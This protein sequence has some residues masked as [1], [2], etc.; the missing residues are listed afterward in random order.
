MVRASTASTSEPR[1]A[2]ETAGAAV[3]QA[4]LKA[5]PVTNRAIVWKP[6]CASVSARLTSVTG[7]RGR[8]I[9]RRRGGTII[10]LCYQG[11]LHAFDCALI[12]SARP[13]RLCAGEAAAAAAGGAGGDRGGK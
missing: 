12:S 11:D 3:V 9:A 6:H 4:I 7:R 13:A 8:E 2:A 10:A 1:N 5:A